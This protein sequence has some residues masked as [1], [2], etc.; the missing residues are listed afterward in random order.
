MVSTNCR[1]RLIIDLHKLFCDPNICQKTRFPEPLVYKKTATKD[2]TLVAIILS[3]KSFL[4]ISINKLSF[5][6]LAV[7]QD[8]HN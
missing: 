6:V 3:I 8:E 7:V 2:R 4:S 1:A 5:L